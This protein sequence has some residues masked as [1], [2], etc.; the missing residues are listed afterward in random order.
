MFAEDLAQAAFDAVADDC[1]AHR[2]RHGESQA[3][4][5]ATVTL[6]AKRGEKRGGDAES[7]VIDG[8][9]FRGT[10][11]PGRLGEG[12]RTAASRFQL[13]LETRTA[14]SSLT[15]SLCRPRAL[16]RDRTARPSLVF[17][18]VRNP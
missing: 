12:E 10:Q 4:R 5:F 7:M 3:S 1:S 9:E 8:S 6:A 2:A 14:L 13:A 17:I 16:R 11:D 18:R 15:D